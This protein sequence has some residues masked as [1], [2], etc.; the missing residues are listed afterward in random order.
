METHN[1][2]I[3]SQILLFTIQGVFTIIGILLVIFL[4]SY[5]SS[6]FQSRP[7][8]EVEPLHEKYKFYEKML[9]SILL[10]KSELKEEKK[11]LKKE[12]KIKD[13]EP[14]NKVFV[15]D[16][17][18]DMQANQVDNLRE[19]ITAILMAATPKDEVVV[20]IESPGGVVHG[21]GL[22]ASQLCRFRDK[23]IPLTVCIDKVAA[24][25]GYLMA[26]PA[27]KI[28][29][30]P[31]AIVGSIGVI[32]QVPNF[33]RLLKK[34][35]VDYK[36]YTAGEFKRTVSL[37]GEISEKGERKFLQQIESTHILFKDYI[38]Q[39]R[40]HIDL[41]AVS[42]G[43]YWYG[44]QAKDLNLVDEIKTSDDYLLNLAKTSQVIKIKYN[45]KLPL[46]EKLTGVLGK[47]FK[48]A[49]IDSIEH[50]ESRNIT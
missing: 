23:G 42:T 12:N 30:A 37:L 18:G 31:F 33:H 9:K 41:H 7:E 35:D 45:K 44:N 11:K 2:D 27:N 25:G 43:E 26:C 50:F 24:S 34:W 17:K 38:R 48:K 14:K 28:I 49:M 36:E 8:I 47:S 21:Y 3:F 39:F 32:A 22:A 4:I 1:T 6:R 40:P 15:L 10:S 19:E 20:K 13:K 5:I 29:C 46:S 16:F